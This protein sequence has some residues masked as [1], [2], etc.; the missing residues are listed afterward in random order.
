[1]KFVIKDL[2]QKKRGYQLSELHIGQ[3][4]TLLVKTIY[5]KYNIQF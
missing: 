2:I 1:M 3:F 4:N 5:D